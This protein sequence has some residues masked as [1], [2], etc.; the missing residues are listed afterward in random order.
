MALCVLPPKWAM[1][2]APAERD[3]VC[4]AIQG[5][6]NIGGTSMSIRRRLR[7]ASASPTAGRHRWVAVVLVVA[8][9]AALSIWIGVEMS[10]WPPP[11][12]GER[13]GAVT[14]TGS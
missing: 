10:E 6:C 4:G 7:R 8:V 14:E 3:T 11:P 13:N 9:L 2:G 12:P 5:R 1:A